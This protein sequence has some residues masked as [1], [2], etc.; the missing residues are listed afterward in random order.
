MWKLKFKKGDNVKITTGRS[1]GHV[2]RII[3]MFPKKSVALIEG[4]NLVSRH[5]KPNSENPDGGI[6]KKEAPIHLSN[7]MLVDG[8]GNAS[9][10]GV[11]IDK[12]T[13]KKSK[14]FKTTGEIIK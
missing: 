12:K 11:K 5:T 2:G 3:S 13:G 10:V 1:K 14:Y 9:K 4:A 7:L 6:I 8:K